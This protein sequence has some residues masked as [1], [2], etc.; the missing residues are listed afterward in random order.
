MTKCAVVNC[1]AYARTGGKIGRNGKPLSFFRF[2]TKEPERSEWLQRCGR[3]GPIHD[4]RHRVCSDHFLTSDLDLSYL[5]KLSLGLKVERQRLQK[6]A[7]PSQYLPSVCS[8]SVP[9][10]NNVHHHGI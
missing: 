8:R 3:A 10:F 9:F 4:K 2:P 7:V 1:K 6:G 5:S